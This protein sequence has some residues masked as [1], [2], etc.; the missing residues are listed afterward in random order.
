MAIHGTN[1]QDAKLRVFGSNVKAVLLFGSETWRLTKGLEQKLQVLINK[2]LRNILWIWWP[3]KFSSKELWRQTT[4]RGRNK[5]ASLVLDRPHTL[6]RP[7][8]HVFKR[9]LEWNP[10]RGI[11]REEDPRTSG[12]AQEWQSWRRNILRVTRQKALHK[13]GLGGALVEDLCFT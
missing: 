12:D 1:N 7:D 10:Y 8:G 2:S 6:R 3:R 4:D 13:I 9:A 5:T 11:E